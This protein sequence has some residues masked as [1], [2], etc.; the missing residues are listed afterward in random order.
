MAS[1]PFQAL[2]PG[3]RSGPASDLDLDELDPPEQAPC[4]RCNAVHCVEGGP[5]A[6]TLVCCMRR[7]GHASEHLTTLGDIGTP[8]YWEE[9]WEL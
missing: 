4:Q 1:N 8:E 3:T 6:G 9:L 2:E 7:S 5:W